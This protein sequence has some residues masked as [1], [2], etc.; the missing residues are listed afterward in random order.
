M[1]APHSHERRVTRRSSDARRADKGA[2]S[3]TLE[4]AC[5]QCGRR[6]DAGRLVCAMCGTILRH[7]RDGARDVQPDEQG[8]DE[9]RDGRTRA[10]D[11]ASRD[12][13]RITIDAPD[14]R[15]D[16]LRALIAR[17]PSSQEQARASVNAPIA[18]AEPRSS[19]S[20]RFDHASSS[21]DPSTHFDRMSSSIDHT[22]R[23]AR[24]IADADRAIR[25]MAR[26]DRESASS[27]RTDRGSAS[28]ARG[29]RALPAARAERTTEES[30]REAW[31][32]LGIGL[33]T[34][35]IFA[36]T[37]LLNYMGWFLASLV[38]E[39]GHAAFAW[40]CGMPAMPA[41]SLDG[42][43]AAV[44]S[45]QSLFLVALIA[46]GLGAGAWN[47]FTGRVRWI[48]LAL[49]AVAY[50]AIALT[51]AKELLH[52]LAGHGGELAFATLCLWKTLDGGF[53]DSKLE[54]A[55]YG[56]LGWFL[57]GKN[58]HLCFAL[59]QSAGARAE[60]DANGS[61][62][63]TNDYIRVAED[64]LHC[65]LQRVALMMLVACVFVLPAALGLWRVSRAM[66]RA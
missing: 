25:S 54:R 40:L 22:D 26:G 17:S 57:L 18:R 44:H 37:P 64:V 29:D 47:V 55:L 56:M 38:H 51:S 5:S 35:P 41:I 19:S 10:I 9:R 66:R 4:L 45:E 34:A 20:A 8:I 21:I 52:L 31:M 33:V 53:T 23:A 32:Y 2:M 6:H 49:L 39:M 58:A 14:P 60:Y 65:P 15:F 62:G 59:M 36:L 42:H 63:L 28:I 50:P 24:S 61:F 7:E 12:S 1:D 11:H 3:P 27:A 48:V 43:A 30:A 13:S 16:T 46:L